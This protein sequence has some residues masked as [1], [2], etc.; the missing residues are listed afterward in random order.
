MPA[1]LKKLGWSP[2]RAQ[3]LADKIVVDPARG[4]GQHGSSNERLCRPSAVHAFLIRE[5]TIKDII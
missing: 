5:W 4:S 3:Y 2:A 1:I